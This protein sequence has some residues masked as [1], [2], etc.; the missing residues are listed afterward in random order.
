MSN[1]VPY[2]NLEDQVYQIKVV[3]NDL[4][5]HTNMNAFKTT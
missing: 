4:N 3:Q 5:P 1:F 2:V